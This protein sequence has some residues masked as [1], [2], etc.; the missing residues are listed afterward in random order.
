MTNQTCNPSI[1]TQ[2]LGI[3]ATGPRTVIVPADPIIWDEGTS[4]EYLTLVASKDFGQG[5]VAKKDVPA[6]TP[7]TNGEYW[8]PVA[9]FNAQLAQ[10]QTDMS[11]SKSEIATL[12]TNVGDNTESIATV[13]SGLVTANAQIAS[14]MA[15]YK[16]GKYNGMTAIWIGDS[17]VQANSLG[18]PTTRFSRQVCDFFGLTEKNYAIGGTGY[19]TSTNSFYSQLQTAIADPSVTKADVKFVFVGGGR[20]DAPNSNEDDWTAP[21]GQTVKS[22]FSQIVNA[23]AENYPNATTVFIPMLYDAA[24]MS[25]YQTYLYGF[26]NWNV[27]DMKAV[28]VPNAFQWLNG[29]YEQILGTDKIHPAQTGH[30][31]LAACIIRY[32]LS[33]TSSL[34]A[35]KIA[36]SSTSAASSVTTFI[37]V[38]EN[39]YVTLSGSLNT[40][41]SAN[42]GA[43]LLQYKPTVSY[44]ASGALGAFRGTVIGFGYN[45]TNNTIVPMQVI[46]NSNYSTN[47]ASSIVTLQYIG[48]TAIAAKSNI[49]FNIPLGYLGTDWTAKGI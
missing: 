9:S 2:A 19:S 23:V 5:Y 47:N 21:S 26:M 48:E 20:N 41:T 32:L 38:D 27:R 46:C 29:R 4:Y 11:A 13:Q 22:W 16:A 24:A 33:G 1:L 17:Y 18:S 10:L 45:F 49:I 6:G 12:K 36:M 39:G 3:T 42:R 43:N 28:F 30:N 8:I 35:I 15:N 7:L 14:I 37:T 31:T 25:V 34:P 40:L 44:G